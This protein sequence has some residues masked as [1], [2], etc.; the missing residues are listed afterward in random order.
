M[1]ASYSASYDWLL[2][3]QLKHYHKGTADYGYK[4]TCLRKTLL[5]FVCTF[6]SCCEELKEASQKDSLF[7]LKFAVHIVLVKPEHFSKSSSGFVIFTGSST[8]ISSYFN[9]RC[10]QEGK[11]TW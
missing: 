1:F 4:L 11:Y 7:F 9:V 10:T 8:V 5:I 6:S 2:F 3:A